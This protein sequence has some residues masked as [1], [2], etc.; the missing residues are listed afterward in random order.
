MQRLI[1]KANIRTD[2]RNLAK[3]EKGP[4]EKSYEFKL[5]DKNIYLDFY[6]DYPDACAYFDLK[7]EDKEGNTINALKLWI[8]QDSKDNTFHIEMGSN[9]IFNG[10]SKDIDRQNYKIQQDI[11]LLTMNP[12]ER[13]ETLTYLQQKLKD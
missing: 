11:E 8:P 3:L 9:V 6:C 1:K 7:W 2:E 4:M 10:D 5:T 13:Q 12:E